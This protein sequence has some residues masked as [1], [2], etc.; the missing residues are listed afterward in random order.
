M[1]LKRWFVTEETT[2]QTFATCPVETCRRRVSKKTTCQLLG[3][4]FAPAGSRNI[5]KN[6]NN[7]KRKVQEIDSTSSDDPKTQAWLEANTLECGGCQGRI[8][9]SSGCNKLQCLC[10]YRICWK[11]R[12]VNARCNC[13]PGHVFYDNITR[14]ASFAARPKIAKRHELVDMKS[15]IEMRRDRERDDR[16]D[17]MRFI[18]LRGGGIRD[19]LEDLKQFIE[20]RGGNVC[21]E[22]EDWKHSLE[23]Q[24]QLQAEDLGLEDLKHLL[25]SRAG[26]SRA[27]VTAANSLANSITNYSIAA[28][29]PPAR[30]PAALGHVPPAGGN[31]SALA[32]HA[33]DDSTDDSDNNDSE[34]PEEDSNEN[35]GSDR[36]SGSA[37]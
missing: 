21:T 5:N 32:L 7:K 29:P 14:D 11:C 3:R 31:I 36:S 25:E 17:F 37:K 18:E 13:S 34:N 8:M 24:A 28:A 9:K 22:L 26:G 19:P 23:L 16:R 27:A 4:P 33:E 10:G 30:A 2:G 12:K 20:M 35:A 1:C 15:Y 6:N